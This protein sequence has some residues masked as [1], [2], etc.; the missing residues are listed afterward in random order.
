MKY[1]LFILVGCLLGFF[2]AKL[3]IKPKEYAPV[4]IHTDTYK[5][6]YEAA[7]ALIYKQ[8]LRIDSLKKLQ[9]QKYIIVYEKTRDSIPSNNIPRSFRELA[10]YLNQ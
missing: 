10:D 8:Y 7:N 3:L 1:F 6:K 5:P 2:T 9:K 4:I